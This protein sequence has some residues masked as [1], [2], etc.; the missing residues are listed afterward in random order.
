M[1]METFRDILCR[2]VETLQS[3]FDACS[4]AVAHYTSVP[5][6]HDHGQLSIFHVTKLL[7]LQL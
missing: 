3:Y 4:S 5:N 1:E 7:T 2:Q 6:G